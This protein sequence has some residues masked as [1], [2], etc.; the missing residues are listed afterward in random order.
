MPHVEL[1]HITHYYHH[2]YVLYFH[3]YNVISPCFKSTCEVMW[4]VICYVCEIW[5][6]KPKHCKVNLE[7]YYHPTCARTKDKFIYIDIVRYT[8]LARLFIVGPVFAR[9]GKVNV[10]LKYVQFVLYTL[11]FFC[12]ALNGRTLNTS[13]TQ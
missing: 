11:A 1:K 13:T 12:R 7:I 5:Q 6:S 10:K 9:A 4:I 8:V 3:I 2:I